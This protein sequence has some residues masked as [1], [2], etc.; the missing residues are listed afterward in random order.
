MNKYTN[1]WEIVNKTLQRMKVPGGWIVKVFAISKDML[2]S[3]E[4]IR[5]VNAFYLPDSSYMWENTEVLP[6]PRSSNAK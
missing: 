6:T 3:D 1:T 5:M 4:S 2:T